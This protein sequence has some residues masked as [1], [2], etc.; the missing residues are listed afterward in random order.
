MTVKEF[1][2]FILKRDGAVMLLLIP[3]VF[4]D[5]LDFRNSNREDAVTTLPGKFSQRRRFGLQPNGRATFKLLDQR[6]DI[7]CPSEAMQQVNV[8]RRSAHDQG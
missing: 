8:V 3:D 5:H 1:P 4:P 7:G 2:E 6:S